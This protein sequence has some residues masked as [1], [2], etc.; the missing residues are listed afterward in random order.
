MATI[1]IHS[2]DHVKVDANDLLIV[3]KHK[4]Y[5]SGRY[6][7]ANLRISKGVWKQ[8]SMHRFLTGCPTGMQVDHIDGDGL[9]NSRQNLR[10]CTQ[11]ENGKNRRINKTNK[12]GYKGVSF[13][14]KSSKWYASIKLDGKSKN[15]GYFTTPEDAHL[16]YVTAAKTMHGNFASY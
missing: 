12:S 8:V 4:W 15:L 16:A 5:R 10:I 7:V 9:N 3:A 6:V 1:Q 2:G 14:N 11:S 13:C